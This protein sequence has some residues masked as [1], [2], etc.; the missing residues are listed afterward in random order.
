MCAC[1]CL[2]GDLQVDGTPRS[3]AAKLLGDV[4]EFYKVKG[5]RRIST[6]SSFLSR[7]EVDEAAGIAALGDIAQLAAVRAK[8]PPQLLSRRSQ[9]EG[10]ARARAGSVLLSGRAARMARA[11]AP[12][13]AAGEHKVPLVTTARTPDAPLPALLA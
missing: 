7:R 12:A 4:D 3:K 8:A 1:V 5:S 11:G 9:S 6:L 2:V 10:G 13:A